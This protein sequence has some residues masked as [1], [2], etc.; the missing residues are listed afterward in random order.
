MYPPPSLMGLA[1]NWWT[2]D[3][4]VGLLGG[5]VP[6]PEQATIACLS[7]DQLRTPDL[8]FGQWISN[9]LVL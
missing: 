7:E 2:V 8:G 5:L 3:A 9:N 6:E 4:A 1:A